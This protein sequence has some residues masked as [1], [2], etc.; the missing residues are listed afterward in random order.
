MLDQATK[1]LVDALRH[2]EFTSLDWLGCAASACVLL[3][4]CMQS[5]IR[6]RL[7]ALLSNIAFISYGWVGR[8]MPILVLHCMLLLI[9]SI[10]L[11]HALRNWTSVAGDQRRASVHHHQISEGMTVQF[12][13]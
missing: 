6:L 11:A 5:M 13:G 2:C 9:N 8:L 7:T 3:T 1:F 4:F 12:G 10:G